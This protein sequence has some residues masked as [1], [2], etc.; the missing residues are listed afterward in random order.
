MN[1]KGKIL[2]TG[3]YFLS[4]SILVPGLLL[5]TGYS[6]DRILGRV[7]N[8]P[9]VSLKIIGL[10]VL[11]IGLWIIGSAT[12]RLWKEGKGLPISSLPPTKFVKEGIYRFCRHPIYVGAVLLFGGF[13]ILIHSFWSCVLCCPLFMGFFI[14]YAVCVEEPVLVRR[15]GDEYIQYRHF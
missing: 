15:F 8:P 10:F 5:F 4:F 6:M 13:S 11:V 2:S 7:F 1:I 14:V 12:I 9:N 3:V